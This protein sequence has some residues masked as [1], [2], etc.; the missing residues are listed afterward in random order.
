MRT[1]KVGML[2]PFTVKR[3]LTV[4][5]KEPCNEDWNAMRPVAGGRYCDVCTKSVVDF[6]G[7]AD[8]EIT[9]Y[10]KKHGHVCG[11]FKTSQLNKPMA[12]EEEVKPHQLKLLNWLLRAAVLIG[13]SMPLKAQNPQ[14][15]EIVSNNSAEQPATRTVEIS[16]KVTDNEGCSI[17]NARVLI[18]ADTLL[19]DSAG[20][21]K[22]IIQLPD[23]AKEVAISIKADYYQDKDMVIGLT[24][25]GTVIVDITLDNLQ[26]YCPSDSMLTFEAK[27]NY[28]SLIT[29]WMGDFTMGVTG[30]IPE[31]PSCQPY[32]LF[33]NEYLGIYKGKTDETED[34]SY[35]IYFLSFAFALTG[36]WWFSKKKANP[37]NY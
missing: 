29:I 37:N 31:N 9:G 28:D 24:D 4:D 32:P 3:T 19:T 10:F 5:I 33:G 21:Y 13:I 23:T 12:F 30:G 25:N 11:R 22:A 17:E 1:I 7:M 26:A 20:Y 34:E 35:Y 27:P 16:G 15:I 8:K 36:T 6:S 14:Q 2:K 18:N